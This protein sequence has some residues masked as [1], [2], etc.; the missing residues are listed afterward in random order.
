MRC[1]YNG[2][3][4]MRVFAMYLGYKYHCPFRRICVFCFFPSQ[5]LFAAAPMILSHEH[6]SQTKTIHSLYLP[7]HFN[8]STQSK[9]GLHDHFKNSSTNCRIPRKQPPYLLQ[10]QQHQQKTTRLRAS[11]SFIFKVLFF[12]FSHL[13]RPTNPLSHLE[14][15]PKLQHFHSE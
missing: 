14:I 13:S 8:F 9:M 10:L 3:S 7:F 11:P 1:L 5:Q 15:W 12:P 4:E 2:V 6:C